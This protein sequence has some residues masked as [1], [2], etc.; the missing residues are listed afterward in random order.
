MYALPHISAVVTHSAT[1][2]ELNRFTTKLDIWKEENAVDN[3]ELLL[4]DEDYDVYANKI[5]YNDE[6]SLYVNFKEVSSTLSASDLRFH[7]FVEDIDP[8]QSSSGRLLRV[9]LRSY[10]RCVVD[11][12]CA[13]QYGSQSDNSTLDTIAEILTDATDGVIPNWVNK[14]P[15]SSDTTSGYSLDSSLVE[16]I[17]GTVTYLY[18]PFK[19]AIN[20]INDSIDIVQAIKGSGTAGC[21][22]IVHP[23]EVAGVVTNYFMLATVGTHSAAAPNIA[24]YW[25]TWWNTTQARSTVEV[26]Q[27][28]ILQNFSWKRP[29][30]NYVIYAGGFRRPADGDR[31]TENNSGLWGLTDPGDATLADDNSAGDFKVNSYSLHLDGATFAAVYQ[32]YYPSGQNLNLDCTKCGGV[33]NPAHIDFY[34]KYTKTTAA[35]PTYI[36][37]WMWAS[38]G[39]YFYYELRDEM[40]SGG[41]W[42]QF[43]LPIGNY[44]PEMFPN[45]TGWLETGTGDWT[46]VDAI[47]FEFQIGGAAPNQTD[48]WLDGLY[49][50]GHVIRGAK[51][52]K[53]GGAVE[54]YY[55]VRTITDQ[56]AKDDSLIA[57]DDTGTMARLA[58]AELLRSSRRPVTGVIA[59]PGQPKIL[60]GQQIHVHACKKVDGTYAVDDTFRI[61]RHHLSFVGGSEGGLRSVLYLTDDLING[62]AMNPLSAYALLR[63]S[64]APEFQTRQS[65]SLK[66]QLI[67][68]TQTVLEKTYDFNDYY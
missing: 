60:A 18:N 25:P 41:P 44:A 23:V 12:P 31:W 45:F 6:V 54:D 61:T 15:W 39:N 46:D 4:G 29:E 67:D 20:V 36:R 68:I 11:L 19:P 50:A 62:M 47:Y 40:T 10:A 26:E 5:A 38:A 51:K 22:W 55:K 24:Q 49:L 32:M 2:Y 56:I 64:V 9:K 33:Y 7:G 58:Y 57:S 13:E 3:A 17:A 53:S 66:A 65:S 27:D 43:I 37:V 35:L 1:D 16:T 63:K 42:R 30:A 34:M 8:V 48:L 52:R 14:I 59:I 28:M 21:H